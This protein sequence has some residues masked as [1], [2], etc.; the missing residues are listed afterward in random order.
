[1]TNLIRRKGLLS[2]MVIVVMVAMLSVACKNR[3]TGVSLSVEAEQTD[4]S[5][6]LTPNASVNFKS[7][8]SFRNLEGY[9]F[10]SAKYNK[11]D[12]TTFVYKAQ[13][14]GDIYDL[15]GNKIKR[16]IIR[17]TGFDKNGNAFSRDYEG[18]R[19]TK[20]YFRVM[21]NNLAN[22][23]FTQDGFLTFKPD[24]FGNGIRLAVKDKT[25][26]DKTKQ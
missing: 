26:T 12:G 5:E 9:Y 18:T 2:I 15:N 19:A 14:M 10:E 4:L 20:G 1:M 21:G 11:A 16:T 3:T 23:T 7:S 13:I 25:S 17:F 8:D 24:D 6:E 22:A